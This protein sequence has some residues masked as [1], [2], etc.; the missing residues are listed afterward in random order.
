MVKQ[1]NKRVMIT[2]TDK[3]LDNI[4]YL[5]ELYDL[6]TSQLIKMLLSKEVVER[7]KG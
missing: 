1:G 2:C 3:M 4:E 6:S 7:K 5:C